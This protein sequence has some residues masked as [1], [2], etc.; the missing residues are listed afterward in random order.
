MNEKKRARL[1]RFCKVIALIVAVL[2]ILGVFL[3]GFV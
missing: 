2:M 3:Q 1:M